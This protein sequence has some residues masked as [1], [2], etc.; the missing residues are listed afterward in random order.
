MRGELGG[1][2]VVHR[3]GRAGGHHRAGSGTHR[4]CGSR[5]DAAGTAHGVGEEQAAVT[6]STRST[7]ANSKPTSAARTTAI[8]SESSDLR[9]SAFAAG[10]RRAFRS[11]S[12]ARAS[13]AISSGTTRKVRA[14]GRCR[15]IS[16]RHDVLDAFDAWRRAVGVRVPARKQTDEEAQARRR[17]R[18]LPEHLDRVCE[19]VTARRA[20]MTPPPPEFDAV[21]ETMTR[22]QRRSGT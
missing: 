11:R 17:K 20:A 9:S 19:R 1:N 5:P 10:L 14:A 16:A 18:S 6:P 3:N 22:K 12:P 8:S 21:L 7:A 2:A 15:L 13:I 4:A